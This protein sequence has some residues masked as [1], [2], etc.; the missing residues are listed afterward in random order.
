METLLFI[1]SA[2]CV[3]NWTVKMA[4][5]ILG[6]DIGTPTPLIHLWDIGY[7]NTYVAFF[8][9]GYQTYFWATHFDIVGG[10]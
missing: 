4:G 6:N 1:I 10:F 3:I 7:G 5:T 8:G 2:V 9:L